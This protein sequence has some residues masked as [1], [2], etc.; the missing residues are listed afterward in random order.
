MSSFGGF[1]A[2]GGPG[3]G[4]G[5]GEEQWFVSDAQRDRVVEYLRGAYVDG[6]LSPAEFEARVGAALAAVTRAD[7]NAT[8]SGLAQVP[9]WGRTIERL[10]GDRYESLMAGFVGLTPLVAGPFGPMF[11]VAV[12]RRGSWIRRQVAHQANFQILSV[13]LAGVAFV[14]GS[15]FDLL[16]VLVPLCG[17]GWFGL[18]I[19]HAAR[20]FEGREWRNPLLKVFPLRIFD[21]G[22]R[23][24][25][26]PTSVRAR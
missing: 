18:T 23:R 21:D 9:Q 26:G 15:H 6:R 2:G 11:G 10:D 19:T 14:I 12:T 3:H 13:L 16:S 7:L 22:S 24:A 5:P 1:P 25:I 4:H 8:L 20:A 17:L